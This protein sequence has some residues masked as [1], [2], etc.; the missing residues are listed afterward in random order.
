VT[1][2]WRTIGAVLLVLAALAPI[3]VVLDVWHVWEDWTIEYWGWAVNLT[4]D[5]LLVTVLLCLAGAWMCARG[6]VRS[7]RNLTVAALVGAAVYIVGYTFLEA[8]L[9]DVSVWSAITESLRYWLFGVG[10]NDVGVQ[11]FYPSQI[12]A[13]P[14][15][16]LLMIAAL[17]VIVRAG[18]SMRTAEAAGPQQ[19]APPPPL[20]A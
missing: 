1:K 13:G 11:T 18:R 9:V 4:N 19:D 17:V 6:R 8:V 20:P 3:S 15:A 14:V 10:Y 12:L 7:A 16:W 2:H 5:A